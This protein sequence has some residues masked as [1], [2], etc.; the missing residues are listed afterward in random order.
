MELP[1]HS[2]CQH[3]TTHSAPVADAPPG[4]MWICPMHP[5]VRQ[6]HPAS[7]PKCGMALEPETVSLDEGESPEL[8]DM[9]R[10]FWIGLLLG[11]P[12]FIVAMAGMFPGNPFQSFDTAVLNWVQLVLATPIVFWCGWPFFERAWT[13]IV[14]RSPNMFTLITLGVGAAYGYSVAATLMPSCFPEGFH[15][16]AHGV[17]TYFDTAVVVTVLVL[18]GQIL[19]LRA[20]GQTTVA[21]RRL[22]G[23]APKTARVVYPDGR[24]EDVTL[25]SIRPGLLLRVRPGEKVPVDGTVVEG[26]STVDE[27]MLTGEPL[28]LEKSAGDTVIGGTV[29][30]TGSFVMRAD[31]VG[32]QTMLAQIV[33]L[34]G[35]AQRSRAPVE[36]VVNRVAAWFVPLVLVMSLLTFTGWILLPSEPRLTLALL[37][38]VAVLI[39]ACPCA[40]GLATPMAVMVGTGRGAESG[41]LIKNAQALEVLGK[42]DILVLDKTGTLTEGKPSVVVLEPLSGFEEAEV[43]QLAASIERSSEHPLAAAILARAKKDHL[44]LLE[45]KNFRSLA[46]KG[47]AGDVAGRRVLLGTPAFLHEQGIATENIAARMETLR[48]QGQ[49]VVL[50]A[51]DA[52]LAGLLGIADPIR[53]TTPEAIDLLHREG[54][55]LVMLTGDSRTT[56]EAVAKQLGIDTVMAEVLPQQKA[57]LVR[58]LQEQGHIVAMAG[59]GVNDA[60]AL[61]QAD[62]G[63]AMGS[64]TDVAM[65]TAS[66]TLV[67]GDL[68]AIA[69][70][71]RLSHATL[72]GIRQNLFLAFAYNALAIPVAT[73]VLYPLCGWLITPIWASVAMSLSS[74]SVIANALRLRWSKL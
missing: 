2:C 46:G 38:A 33:R 21:I 28:P 5:E 19:E 65:H 73:G 47:I 11:L 74:L 64:G 36:R 17:E 35:E 24:E 62:I 15:S 40:L 14:H 43:L 8:V 18:L 39:I 25:T 51:V 7:C 12:V 55:K 67:R 44:T 13:S 48:R 49:T 60:P 42:A 34:V 1:Q 57:E 72:S 20:R 22:L 52:Q 4:T 9:S 66:I 3:K 26:T 37:N 59:D 69:R 63:L 68:R 45:V 54:L 23:L 30:G 61:A 71:R 31:K 16:G 32:N 41:I 53:A 27:S 29:N 6:D 70:A 10:R 58:C 56:A 50:L